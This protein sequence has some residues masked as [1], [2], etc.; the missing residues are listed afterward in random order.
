[1]PAPLFS[2]NSVETGPV[3]HLFYP[4]QRSGVVT[5]Q[6]A[7]SSLRIG[8]NAAHRLRDLLL[9]DQ[10]SWLGLYERV[11]VANTVIWVEIMAIRLLRLSLSA[12]ERLKRVTIF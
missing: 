7:L 10:L 12:S 11:L 5:C 4:S 3:L 1:M 8:K 9:V 2:Q 6:I